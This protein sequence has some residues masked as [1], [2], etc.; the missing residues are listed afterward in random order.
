M[1]ELLGW[2]GYDKAVDSQD[3]DQLDLKCFTPAKA[4]VGAASGIKRHL[5]GKAGSCPS[6]RAVEPQVEQPSDKTGKC[7][8]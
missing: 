3:T 2:Y 4:G 7:L 5:V 1:N 8:L 6:I